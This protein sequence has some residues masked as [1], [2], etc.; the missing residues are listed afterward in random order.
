ME[1]VESGFRPHPDALQT[2]LTEGID[3]EEFC[4]HRM[5]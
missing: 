1:I 3:M 4:T 2:V 5:V